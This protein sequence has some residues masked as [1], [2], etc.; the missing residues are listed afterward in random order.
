M[1]ASHPSSIK[2]SKKINTETKKTLNTIESTEDYVIATLNNY[3]RGNQPRPV[4]PA[5]ATQW[6]NVNLN[7]PS[8][9]TQPNITL[10]N[11]NQWGVK[12]T[13]SSHYKNEPSPLCFKQNN[14]SQFIHQKKLKLYI[15]A[16]LSHFT[17][18]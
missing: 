1:I 11:H 5:P 7:G 17:I 16:N 8:Q 4:S 12:S 6:S 3:T 9:P 10:P 13:T 2:K 14:S 18:A 15:K